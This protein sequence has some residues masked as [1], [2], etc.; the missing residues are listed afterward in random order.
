[1]AH[2]NVDQ[3]E[4]VGQLAVAAGYSQTP[5]GSAVPFAELRRRRPARCA[6]VFIKTPPFGKASRMS[7]WFSGAGQMPWVLWRCG[8]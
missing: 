3:D 2:R 5:I 6:K 8:A 7:A 1:M 4:R